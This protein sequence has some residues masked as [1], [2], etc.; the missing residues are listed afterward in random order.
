MLPFP[1]GTAYVGQTIARERYEKA[2]CRHFKAY[3]APEIF[4]LGAFAPQTDI[5]DAPLTLWRYRL[6]RQ[7]IAL[8][9]YESTAYTYLVDMSAIPR[10]LR[11][12]GDRAILPVALCDRAADI[13]KK[14]RPEL[15]VFC[16]IFPSGICA[17]GMTLLRPDEGFSLSRWFPSPKSERSPITGLPHEIFFIAR[18]P[19]LSSGSYPYLAAEQDLSIWRATF[20]V[21]GGRPVD[22]DQRKIK[23]LYG[24]YVPPKAE[25]LESLPE[26][27]FEAITYATENWQDIPAPL[28]LDGE[29]PAGFFPFGDR[30][31]EDDDL[32][33][34]L[35]A[36]ERNT[37]E[38]MR[39]LTGLHP[40]PKARSSWWR[41]T[42]HSLLRP[43]LNFFAGG[44]R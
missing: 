43:F 41:L 35:R 25:F 14:P 40:T 44:A 12:S 30:A 37:R 11:R 24:S 10:D 8:R 29:D 20:R 15:L 7:G 28:D 38:T 21:I 22:L 42:E 9:R 34:L 1:D 18:Y 31:P 6:G 16:A 4:T 17:F 32:H 33:T 39:F 13:L 5:G 19:Q 23:N 26:P 3:G 27:L 36:I 2:V